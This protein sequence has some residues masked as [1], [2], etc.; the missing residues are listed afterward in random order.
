MHCVIPMFAE[1]RS[2]LHETSKRYLEAAW[3]SAFLPFFAESEETPGRNFHLKF[4]IGWCRR[5]CLRRITYEAY[6]S[7][8]L[9]V[10]ENEFYNSSPFLSLAHFRLHVCFSHAGR[11]PLNLFSMLKP[12]AVIY[13]KTHRNSSVPQCC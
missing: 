9:Q 2:D 8:T 12:K 11:T 7:S 13:A 10:K 6:L 3:T 5:L 4:F 1:W